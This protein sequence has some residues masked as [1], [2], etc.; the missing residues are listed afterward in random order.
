MSVR[1]SDAFPRQHN[2]ARVI[3]SEHAARS[4]NS[5]AEH[6]LL[7]EE[8]TAVRKNSTDLVFLYIWGLACRMEL[9]IMGA[10]RVSFWGLGL[11]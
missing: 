4:L 9:D 2:G 1:Q 11:A 8:Q 10:E 3:F 6:C 5:D 7:S